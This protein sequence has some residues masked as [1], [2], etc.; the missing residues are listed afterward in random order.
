MTIDFQIE[1]LSPL[2]QRFLLQQAS[3]WQCTPE[4]AMTRILDERA[5]KDPTLKKGAAAAQ[6]DPDGRPAAAAGAGSGA[7]GSA[8]AAN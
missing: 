5:A 8:V 7:T 6:G 2:G 4:A 3:R 1:S